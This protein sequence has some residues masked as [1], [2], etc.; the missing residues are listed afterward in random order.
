M[1]SIGAFS[2]PLGLCSHLIHYILE[3]LD[4]VKLEENGSYRGEIYLEMT[5]FAAQPPT[6]TRRPSKLSPSERLWRPPQSATPPSLT[7]AHTPSP[8]SS[9]RHHPAALPGSPGRHAPTSPTGTHLVPPAASRTPSPKHAPLPALPEEAEPTLQPVPS[10]LRPRNAKSSPTPLP[11]PQPAPA[12]MPQPHLHARAD[13]SSAGPLPDPYRDARYRSALP[14]PL[15]PAAALPDPYALAERRAEEE[16][17]RLGRASQEVADAELAR[18]MARNEGIDVE[19]MRAEEADAEVARRLERELNAG[20]AEA[21][22]M[23]GGW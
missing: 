15:A 1:V 10:V 23:P 21:P 19:R 18:I 9:P 22:P 11:A 17:A 13:D 8:Q 3:T 7:P 6:V 16:R 2:C 12:G 5:F 14:L 20:D 4:W